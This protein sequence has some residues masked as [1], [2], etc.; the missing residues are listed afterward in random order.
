M[1]RGR[2][3]VEMEMEFLPNRNRLKSLELLTRLDLLRKTLDKIFSGAR[4]A[5]RF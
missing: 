1:R 3:Q 4:P 5:K 2:A